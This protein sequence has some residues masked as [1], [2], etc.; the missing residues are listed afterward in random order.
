MLKNVMHYQLIIITHI[1]AKEH[2]PCTIPYSVYQALCPFN[3]LKVFM[4]KNIVAMPV[5]FE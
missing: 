1:E 4:N 3:A 5:L 2:N